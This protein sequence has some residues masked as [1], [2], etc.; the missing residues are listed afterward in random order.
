VL[1]NRDIAELLARAG[2]EAE[3]HVRRALRR[4][5]RAALSWPVEAATLVDDDRLTSLPRVGPY[6]GRRIREWLD[7]DAPVPEPPP[8]RRD[9]LTL[10][11]AR[12]TLAAKPEWTQALRGDLQVHTVWSDGTGTIEEMAEAAI[13]RGHE[14]IAITDHTRTL[15]IAGGLDEDR[16]AAQG[17][18][19]A[20]VNARLGGRFRLLRAAEMNLAPDGTGDMPRP[21]LARLDV[22]LGAF[23]SALRRRDDQTARY[24]A[25]LENPDVHVLAHPRGR[26]Y[27]FRAGLEADWA[28]VFAVAAEHDKAVEIDAYPD[29]QDLDVERLRLAAAAGVRISIGSDAH[30]PD[31]LGAIDF[32]LAA[33]CRAGIAPDRIVN[34][35]PADDLVAWAAGVHAG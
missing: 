13:R 1:G 17:D 32:G 2:E 16:L 35:L 18:E 5:S 21:A 29:R 27:D 24:V 26:I 23:H 12:A 11:E 6:I 31:Q 4:A 25:A 9:F 22:V 14:Y 3:G 30:H 33:A 28:R 7:A 20:A 10:S 34:F 8:L 15:R 19:I